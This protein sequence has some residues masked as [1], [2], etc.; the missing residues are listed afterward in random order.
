M[1]LTLLLVYQYYLSIFKASTQRQRHKEFTI[2]LTDAANNNIQV[3]SDDF[4][5]NTHQAKQNQTWCCTVTFALD[6]VIPV[7]IHTQCPRHPKIPT[8]MMLKCPSTMNYSILVCW[9]CVDVSWW[10]RHKHPSKFVMRRKS[11]CISLGNSMHTAW[12][13]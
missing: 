9:W 5:P 2:I 3:W 13:G 12:W 10:N 1:C 8:T 11:Y 4:Q 6:P 7:A